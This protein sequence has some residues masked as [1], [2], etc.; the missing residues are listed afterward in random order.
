MSARVGTPDTMT[1]PART[2][3]TAAPPATPTIHVAVGSNLQPEVHVPA[4]L[5]RLR[6]AF[7]AV[8]CSPFYET[9]ALDRPEQPAYWN[10]VVA[11]ASNLDRA[12]ITRRLHAIETAE[13]RIRTADKWAARTLDLDILSWRGQ[14]SDE[15][16]TRPFLARAVA[17]LGDLPAGFATPAR[18][19]PVVWRPQAEP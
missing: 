8:R 13:G 6:R 16:R 10:G 17:D 18:A 5:G 2:A 14:W 15:L 1:A 4:A 7:G 12:A 3:T 11:L 19:W 9:P